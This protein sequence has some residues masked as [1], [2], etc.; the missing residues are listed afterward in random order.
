MT[1][2]GRGM[3]VIH[4]EDL[5]EVI[6]SI[7]VASSVPGEDA[8]VVADVIAS[9]NLHGVDG[10]GISTLPELV[11]WIKG[12]RSDDIR[13]GYDPKA[14]IKTL[15]D[16]PAFA[17][18]DATGQF[19]HVVA[20]KAMNLAVQKGKMNGFVG[21]VGFFNC[22]YTGPNFHYGMIAL[23]QDMIGII[24]SKGIPDMATWGGAKGVIGNNPICV[25]IPAGDEKPII[26]DMATSIASLGTLDMMVRSGEEIPL[27]YLIDENGQLTNDLD[28]IRRGGAFL[29][30]GEHKGSGIALVLEALTGAL[31]GFGCSFDSEGM[32]L[33]MTAIN[34]EQFQPIEKFKSI[35]DGLVR[36]VKASPPRAGFDEVLLPGER[37]CI[38][39]EKRMREGIP[40]DDIFWQDVVATA[41]MVGLELNLLK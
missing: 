33:M 1:R 41:K 20:T 3:P 32:A 37:E 18:W 40:I 4:Y 9:A 12:T 2:E 26:L 15:R 21:T 16:T 39:R 35:I 10:Q 17:L 8:S 30:F 27:G 11:H 25:T 5:R 24:T 13:V 14:E 7:L 31:T 22:S 38:T 29:P 6:N 34:I 23:E 19:G 28:A 36:H